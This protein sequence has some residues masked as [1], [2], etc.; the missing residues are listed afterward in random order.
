[1]HS[2]EKWVKMTDDLVAGLKIMLAVVLSTEL[3]GDPLWMYIIG[4]AGGGK[5]LLLTSLQDSNRTIFRSSVT[6]RALVSGF[7][8]K[9]DPS[10]LPHLD[11]KCLIWKDFTEVLSMHPNDKDEVFGVLRGAYD[12]FVQKTFGNG[13]N[14]EYTVHFSMLA[15]VTPAINGDNRASLGERFLKFQMLKDENID[16][17]EQIRAA[18]SMVAKE[19]EMEAELRESASTFINGR[20]GYAATPRVPE[21]I[22]E[23]VVALAQIIAILRASVERNQYNDKI[24][25]RPQAEVGTRLA[26]QLVKLAKMLAIVE[27]EDAVTENI[28]Q[29][30]ERV[31]F[32]SA[33]GFHIEVVQ[34][35]ILLGPNATEREITALTGLPPTNTHRALEDLVLL[36]ALKRLPGKGPS[37]SVGHRP[38]L[39]QLT[40]KLKRLWEQAEISGNHIRRLV[41]GRRTKTAKKANKKNK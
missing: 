2:F 15:G 7:N 38:A 40:P 16:H 29:L 19:N 4:P 37:A 23:R 12:G 3:P 25:Y 21:C 6:P 33:T 22:K 36:R 34:A 11:N 20:T 28:H 35:V 26:K 39:Y 18:I 5:T 17:S 8:S 24:K 30:I 9:P 32:D 27:K 1:M 10:L 13:V 14:R 31:A 41:G